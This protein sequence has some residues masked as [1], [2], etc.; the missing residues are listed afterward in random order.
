MCDQRGQT[1]HGDRNMHVE[2]DPEQ[3]LDLDVAADAAQQTT[4]RTQLIGDFAQQFGLLA[5][6]GLRQAFDDEIDDGLLIAVVCDALPGRTTF[7][8][9]VAVSCAS[10]PPPTDVRSMALATAVSTSLPRRRADFI[11]W[12]SRSATSR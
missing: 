12:R 8:E 9:S 3:T 11:I 4:S 2:P 7:E 10:A 1:G 6:R 5:M